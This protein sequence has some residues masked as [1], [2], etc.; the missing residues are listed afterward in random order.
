MST[1]AR[2]WEPS[3]SITLLS[4]PYAI[5]EASRNLEDQDAYD[6]IQTLIAALKLVRDVPGGAVPKGLMPPE[7]HLP[8]LLAA[9][10]ARGDPFADWR[11]VAFWRVCRATHR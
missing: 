9:I 3:L 10:A 7:K 8:I 4:S 11:T 5:E 1:L 2:L 6:F